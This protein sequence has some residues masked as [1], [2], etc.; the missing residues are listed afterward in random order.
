MSGVIQHKRVPS[1]MVREAEA[2]RE[3]AVD[4]I[5]RKYCDPKENKLYYQTGQFRLN[6]PPDVRAAHWWWLFRLMCICV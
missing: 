5:W 3:Q 2:K 1:R 6:T 4:A